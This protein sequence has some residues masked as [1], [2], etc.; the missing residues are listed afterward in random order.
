MYIFLI[1]RLVKSRDLV[2]GCDD[3]VAFFLFISLSLD[4]LH[5][6][7]AAESKHIGCL[8]TFRPSAPLW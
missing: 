3:L 6:V 8:Y 4:S 5:F 1:S 7:Y 2:F